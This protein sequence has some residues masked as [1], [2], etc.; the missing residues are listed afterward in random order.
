MI[1]LTSRLEEF[2]REDIEK[3]K[4]KWDGQ[5]FDVA[6]DMLLLSYT[7]KAMQKLLKEESA[8]K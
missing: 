2:R 4:K 1:K 6:A 8:S 3:L 7:K 5:Y